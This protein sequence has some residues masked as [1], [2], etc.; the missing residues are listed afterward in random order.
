MRPHLFGLTLMAALGACA[1]QQTAPEDH[2]Q[3]DLQAKAFHLTIDLQ[4]GTA[5]VR[6]PQASGAGAG[7]GALSLSLIGSDALAIDAV[8]RGCVPIP[9]TR[10]KRC[11]VTLEI[12]NELHATDLVTPTTFPRP[13]QG[14]TGLL[15]FPWTA[16]ATGTTALA[17][18]SPAWDNGP[19]DFFNDFSCSSGV[20]SDCYRYDLVAAPLYANTT[21]STQVGYDVPVEAMGISAYIVVAADLR[22]NPVLTARLPAVA[23][24][25]HYV[26]GGEV[27]SEPIY[28]RV[29][30]YGPDEAF[31]FSFC[32]FT[33]FLP[34]NAVVRSARARFFLYNATS[35]VD[36]EE[37]NYGDELEASDVDLPA[38]RDLGTD[39][40]ESTN[41]R[42]DELWVTWDVSRAVGDAVDNGQ[43]SVQFRLSVPRD[44][45]A[46]FADPTHNEL[47]QPEVV[48]QYT[49]R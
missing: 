26:A 37:V 2:S 33:N 14:V 15:V 13:P 47:I 7:G 29:G 25:C 21:A 48:V 36:L 16:T 3:P 24:L 11:S 27:S 31:D 28:L 23:S 45:Y 40:A 5:A 44:G 20:K 38:V 30:R 12:S 43:T 4:S 17:V 35:D 22:D 39:R 49:L 46:N 18:P 32:S 41:I 42:F 34:D 8:S 19:V 1:D 6:P 9:R 10:L